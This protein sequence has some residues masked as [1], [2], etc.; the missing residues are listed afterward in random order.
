MEL[1]HRVPVNVRSVVYCTAIAQGNQTV[2]DLFWNRFRNANVA[3]E[4][5][6]IL[7]ALG[8]TKNNVTLIGYLDRI[9]GD[10]V[11]LQDKAS[12]F[13]ATY[14]EQAENV[15]TV[16]DYV[17]ANHERIAQAFGST[18]NVAGILS[19]VAARF[20]T[21]AQIEQLKT[22]RTATAAYTASASLQ[23]AIDDAEFN[24]RWAKKH[25]PVIVDYMRKK[26]G[27]GALTSAVVMVVVAAMFAIFY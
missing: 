23:T 13:A 2:W 26:N 5:V 12:A 3:A 10:G 1:A 6:L 22:F 27:A 14:N 24:Q 16:L 18:S 9:L 21:D 11:R 25:V 15:Q 8:C 7:N 4:Q 19:N 20:T 17:L